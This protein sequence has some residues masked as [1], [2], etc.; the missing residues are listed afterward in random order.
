MRWTILLLA[1]LVWPAVAS[2]T[3]DSG[4]H[5]AAI[6]GRQARVLEILAA[7]PLPVHEEGE[8]PLI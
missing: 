3:D 6:H 7:D 1:S 5:E 8:G 4:I 2:A